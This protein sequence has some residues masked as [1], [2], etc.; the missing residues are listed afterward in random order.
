MTAEWA[1]NPLVVAM[2]D[3]LERQFAEMRAS[4]HYSVRA[5]FG[6]SGRARS[7]TISTELTI[8]LSPA[9]ER[10]MLDVLRH[11]SVR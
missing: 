3:A 2:V 8:D 4:G 6:H 5:N 7:V 11:D 1:K 10:E 9:R